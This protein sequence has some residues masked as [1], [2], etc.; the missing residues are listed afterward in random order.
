[1]GGGVFG[2]PSLSFGDGLQEEN[3]SGWY[4]WIGGRGAFPLVWP[5][6]GAVGG[7]DASILEELPY[8]CAAFGAVIIQGPGRVTM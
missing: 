4:V 5:V 3:W 2:V 7:V 8:E 1:L 6:L